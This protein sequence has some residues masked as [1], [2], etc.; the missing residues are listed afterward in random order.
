[1]SVTYHPQSARDAATMRALRAELAARP[2]LQFGPA[3]RPLFAALMQET[4]SAEVAYV[5]T[6]V[7]GVP[8]WW[9]TPAAAAPRTAILYLHG[10]AYVAGSAL[11]FRHFAG[12]IAARAGVAAFVADYGLAPERPF[13]AAVTDTQAAYRGLVDAGFE[14]VA[15]VGDSAGGGLA[16]ALLAEIRGQPGAQPVAAVTFSPWIDLTLAGAS[17]QTRAAADP[18]VRREGLDDC[19]RLYLGETDRRDPR[20]SPLF[21]DLTRLPP[22]L[23]HVGEDEI[24]LDDSRRLLDGCA[25]VE[26]HVWQGMWHVFPAN[27]A[28]F[29]AADEALGDTS[30]FL[31][32]HLAI[33]ESNLIQSGVTT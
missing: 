8:G 3:I 20:A 9:C 29:A 33:H 32:R 17:M 6:S 4:P 22:V 30:R 23:V 19:A 25:S 12:Q 24:L 28:V 11:A 1:V 5:E 16:L 27:I 2:P 15:V 31:R 18:I 7:G 21:G 13:P 14:R 10:G 26:L